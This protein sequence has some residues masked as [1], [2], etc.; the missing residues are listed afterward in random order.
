MAAA[1]AGRHPAGVDVIEHESEPIE[2]IEACQGASEAWIIDAVRSGA[3]AGRLHRLDA[4]EQPLPA[5]LFGV[6]T[7]RLGIAEALEL[8]RALGRLPAR[9]LVYGIEGAA[10]EAGGP[11]SPAVAAAAQRLADSLTAELAQFA[12]RAGDRA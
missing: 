12:T 3:P 2:L 4:S 11:V 8:A 7:H 9:V 5:S 6:S 1:V 10:F